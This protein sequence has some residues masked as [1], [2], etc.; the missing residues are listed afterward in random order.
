MS[1]SQFVSNILNLSEERIEKLVQIPKSDGSIVIKIKLRVNIG[2][3][4][5]CKNSVK[6]HGYTSKNLT[7]SVFANRSCTLVYLRRRYRCQCCD[8]T[9]SETNPFG[10]IGEN[11]THA[12]KINI[13]DDLKHPGETYSIVAQRYNV[14]VTTVMRIFDKHVNIARK[15]LPEV[16][17]MDE[18]YF[19]NSNYDSLYCVLLMDFRT[20]EII[21]VLPSRKKL[22]VTNY[23]RNILHSTRDIRTMRSELDNIRYVSIDLYDNFR[24]IVH[25]M[26]P[27]AIICAD[28]FHVIKHLTEDFD[29]IRRKCS[30]STENETLKILLFKFKYIFRHNQNLDRP[31]KYNRSLGRYATLRDIREILFANFPELEKAYNLKELYIMFNQNS[32]KAMAAARF[33]DIRQLF[34]DSGIEEYDEF[35]TLLTNWKQE[36]INSFTIIYNRRINN[37]YIESKNGQ[38]ERLLNSANGFTNFERARN[39][40]LYCLNIKDTYLF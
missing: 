14:S 17:S 27:N 33:D 35:V 1:L 12:T 10:S 25:T 39:R 24:D 21:D 11:L 30:N 9:F 15:P 34:A 3:C 37:S 26:M 23:F 5:Y 8:T 6:I 4:P 2:K 31:G 22:N 38:V 20:G 29:K 13:L 16:L 40:I 36:I 7:H 19:P 18:H 32:T 28:S